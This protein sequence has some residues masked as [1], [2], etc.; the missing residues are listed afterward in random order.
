MMK[1]LGARTCETATNADT[2]GNVGMMKNT[3]NRAGSAL[4]IL[5]EK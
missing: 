4:M 5:L 2:G 1:L 3:K